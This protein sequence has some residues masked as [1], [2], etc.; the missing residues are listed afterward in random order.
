MADVE[1]LSHS[2]ICVHDLKEAEDFYC[3]VLGGRQLSRVNFK[4]EDAQKGR[5]VHGTIALEDYLLALMV[6]QD[7]MPMPDSDQQRGAH[8]FRHAFRVSRN[9]FGK[10]MEELKK[11]E[12]AFEGPV[13]HPEKSPFGQSI[14]FKDPSGNFLEILWRRDEDVNYPKPYLRNVG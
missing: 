5:S 11:R 1:S 3:N 4:T 14:Y 13:E 9:R 6:P 10:T 12:I 7:F 8:G 2:A